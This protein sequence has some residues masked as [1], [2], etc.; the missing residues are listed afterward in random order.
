MWQ[1]FKTSPTYAR[2]KAYNELKKSTQLNIKNAKYTFEKKLAQKIKSEP[3]AFY[4]YVPSR[5]N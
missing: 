5:Q 4:A 2:R 1:K 3:K